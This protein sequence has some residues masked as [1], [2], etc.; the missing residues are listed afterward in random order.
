[1]LDYG[2]NTEKYW[3]TLHF[4]MNMSSINS[5][6]HPEKNLNGEYPKKLKKKC[7]KRNIDLLK[8]CMKVLG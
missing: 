1:M 5:V 6:I 2:C 4:E 3:P 8:I 7:K